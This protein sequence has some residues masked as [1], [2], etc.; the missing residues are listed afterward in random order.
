VGSSD[1][2]PFLSAT[3]NPA[4]PTDS[5]GL[6]QVTVTW[7]AP[8]ISP[9]EIHVGAPDGPLMAIGGPTGSATTGVWVLNGTRF[10]LQDVSGGKALT[11]VNTLAQCT[12]IVRP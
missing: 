7:S 3:P 6:V 4:P 1:T 2:A 12:V 10:Y 5:T 9:V 11:G 8:G